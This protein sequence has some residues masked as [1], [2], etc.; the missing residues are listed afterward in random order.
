[1]VMSG[2]GNNV[3]IY[4]MLQRVLADI[5]EEQQAADTYN[6]L[7]EQLWN[8]GMREDSMVLRKM[9]GEEALHHIRLKS[10]AEHIRRTYNVSESEFASGTGMPEVSE[11]Q[12]E[13]GMHG[14]MG[15]HE[16]YMPPSLEERMFGRMAPG[17]SGHHWMGQHR[18][19]PKTYGDW[20]DLGEDIKQADPSV[21]TATAVNKALQSIMS[22][23][24]D[25][26]N[27]KRTLINLAA[28]LRIN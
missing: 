11:E 15:S 13:S 16:Q 20:V 2:N 19:V 10:V 14:M 24:P 23:S 4:E 18:P 5:N 8:A 9:A 12:A 7:A 1:M 6:R 26:D 17:E 25:I 27:A 21:G 22:N 28:K 3:N